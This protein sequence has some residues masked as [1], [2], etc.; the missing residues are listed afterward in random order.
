MTLQVAY[1][2]APNPAYLDTCSDQIAHLYGRNYYNRSF[3]TGA[4]KDPPLHPHDRRSA[5]DS[6][7][8]PFPGLL[9]G[10]ANPAA[11]S[12]VDDQNDYRTNEVA[13]NWN[14]ALVYALAGFLPEPAPVNEG[15]AGN[16]GDAGNGVVNDGPKSSSATTYVA[17]G[18]GCNC[19]VARER[20]APG[21][22]WA[23]I[24]AVTLVLRRRRRSA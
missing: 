10:G 7:T 24:A 3:V 21:W 20:G 11:T 15:D 17:A 23:S 5:S 22:L 2:L 4:G 19:R 16:L 18:G 14:G 6:I 9:V 12:W 1:Q 13:I 8:A